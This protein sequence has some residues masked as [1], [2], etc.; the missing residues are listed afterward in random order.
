MSIEQCYV[1]WK[2]LEEVF[3]SP[4]VDGKLFDASKLEQWAQDLVEEYTG[5]RNTLMYVNGPQNQN[6]K[7]CHV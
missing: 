5:D 7:S 6:E 4:D 2:G 3:D 1:A